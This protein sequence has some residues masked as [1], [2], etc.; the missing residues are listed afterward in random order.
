MSEA[1]LMRL[2]IA[3]VTVTGTAAFVLGL[4]AWRRFRGAPFGTGVAIVVTFCGGFTAYHMVLLVAPEL[5]HVVAPLKTA[6]FLLLVGFVWS[7]IRTHRR[8]G[9][10]TS[11]ESRT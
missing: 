7:M 1:T 8:M 6:S 11:S 4:L 3:L 5:H 10:A 2:S 9:T